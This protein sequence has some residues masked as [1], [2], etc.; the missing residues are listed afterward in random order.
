MIRHPFFSGSGGS[1]GGSDF[2][3]TPDNLRSEDTFE[4][5]LGLCAGPIK[6][7]VGGLKGIKIDGTAVQ[8]E[9]GSENF[10]EFAAIWANGDPTQFPQKIEMRLGSAAA[11]QAV[12]TGLSNTNTGSGTSTPGPWNART[13]SNVAPHYIDLRFIVQQLFRQDKKGTWNTQATLE[14]QLKP[15][16]ATNWINPTTG[17]Q[18]A[19]TGGN[20]GKSSGGISGLLSSF[21]TDQS[22]TNNK[23]FVI[24][25]KTTSPTVVELRLWVPNTG[26]YVS[27]TWDIRIRLLE[28]EE[29]SNDD[30]IEQRQIVWESLAAIYDEEIGEEEDWRGLSWIQMYGKASDNLKG[31]PEVEVITDTKIVSVPPSSVFNPDTRAYTTTVWDGSWVKAFTTDPAWI[32]NDAI[33]DPISGLAK[34]A[35]G[36]H[37]NKWDALEASKWFSEPVPNGDILT[38][39]D[40]S[41]TAGWTASNATLSSTGGRLRVTQTAGFGRATKVLATVPGTT[42]RISK[43]SFAGTANPYVIVGTVAGGSD[44]YDDGGAAG[45]SSDTFVATGTSTYLAMYVNSATVGHYAEFDNVTLETFHPRYSLNIVHN[46]PMKAEDFIRYMAGAVGGLAWDQ[47]DGEWRLKVDKPETPVDI[48]TLDNI[49]G[50]FSYSHTDVDTRYNDYRGT[51]LNAE[52]DYREETIGVVDNTSIATI[53]HKPTTVA[54]IGCTNRQEAVRRLMIRLRSSTNETKVV[55][56]TTNRRADHLLPLDVILVADGDLGDLEARTTGRVVSVSPDRTQIE[57]RDPMQLEIGIDY[58]L[59]FAAFNPDYDPET[60][61]QPTSTLWKNA[62]VVETRDVVNTSGQRGQ[63][64][65]LYLDTALPDDMSEYLVVA[66]EATGLTTLPKQYRILSLANSEEDEANERV[67]VSAV[68]IDTGKWAA[69][70]GVSAQDSVYVDLRTVAPTPLP[71]V[72]GS[73]LNLVANPSEQGMNHVIIA[74]WT[75]PFGSTIDGFK[76]TYGING[77]PHQVLTERTVVP[78]V[79]LNN[80]PHGLYD[81]KIYT[82]TRTGQISLP[83]TASLEVTQ[84][85]IE[86]AQIA[87]ANGQ[88]LEDLQP[89]E[90]GATQNALGANELKD[91]L[92]AEDWGF[93]DDDVSVIVPN[94]TT[95]GYAVGDMPKA[96]VFVAPTSGSQPQAWSGEMHR[97]PAE[98]N[99]RYFFSIRLSRG[100]T[101]T[102]PSGIILRSE[103]LDS[104]YAV[105]GSPIDT[106][107]TPADMTAGAKPKEFL[108]SNVAPAN[109]AFVRM[110]LVATVHASNAGSFRAESPRIAKTGM[111]GSIGFGPTV[112]TVQYDYDGTD[113]VGLGDLIW[114]FSING[115]E[116]T[117]GVTW[118]WKVI[119]GS[120]NT[121]TAA[122]GEQTL[123]STGS[124]LLALTAL[125]A[126]T[127]QIEL[128]ATKDGAT[129]KL[130]VTFI[131]EY[132]LPPTGSSG[133]SAT[134]LASQTVGFAGS[135]T[136]GAYVT[137]TQAGD[138]D[139]TMPAGKTAVDVVV[140]IKTTPPNAVGGLS[141]RGWITKMKV[142]R[143]ISSTWTDQGSVNSGETFSSRETEPG[144]PTIYYKDPFTHTFTIPITGLTAGNTYS[145]RVQQDLDPN[146]SAVEN[147][148][149]SGSVTVVVP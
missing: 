132:G 90:S 20:V 54:L 145:I 143:D 76:V 142:Q 101:L 3:H 107:I 19:W 33:S 116:Q 111:L 92:F 78:T 136:S 36:S 62:T 100:T 75:R 149:N 73:I 4:G 44:L 23:N 95:G 66:L 147:H 121:I 39:T 127:S 83:L 102:M 38:L 67:T 34:F 10:P 68:E 43:T 49:E 82:L 125:G 129:A 37:L 104:S 88:T 106:T 113:P 70:D 119:T 61:T 18:G 48:F 141:T 133:S 72:S 103:Y 35:P 29:Y 120:V 144:T 2:T 123:S 89:A 15:S 140:N 91:E 28:R 58:T 81:F 6:G 110:K 97:V 24:K 31:V 71:P 16:T 17:D 93:Q 11:P 50:E 131:K 98:P 56:F 124:A 117:S 51:F 26:N 114:K 59:R 12:N 122:S 146:P 45:T 79:D 30:D 94:T 86:A 63:V 7:P 74:N 22:T 105:I 99:K 64:T 52:F 65:T 137:I 85:L 13:L 80:P 108:W 57:V 27:T 46:Q 148:T 14:I 96:L 9:S 138:I 77:G 134:V 5:V 55:S 41:T 47:G 115:I 130:A 1:S 139:F 126:D 60:T 112:K 25:G 32:I 118:K 8:N 21:A 128:T 40:G 69:M 53:G 42:Y 84:A 135:G 87:Y 109:T